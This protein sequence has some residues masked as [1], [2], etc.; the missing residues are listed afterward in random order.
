[1]TSQREL[2]RQFY[3]G[4]QD[5]S[6]SNVA[7]QQLAG[8]TAIVGYGHAVYAYRYPS[9]NIVYFHG[10]QGRSTAT[11]SQLGKMGLTEDGNPVDFPDL[12]M[13]YRDN[14]PETVVEATK[15][16]VVDDKPSVGSLSEWL[17]N[18]DEPWL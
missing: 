12:S 14:K 16:H 5:G 11:N 6:G 15:F 1:M 13:N 3:A 4:A 8:G 10:W 9:G 18:Y 17:E 7:I 2:A